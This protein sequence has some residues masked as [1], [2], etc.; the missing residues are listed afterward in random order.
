[1]ASHSK[2]ITLVHHSAAGWGSLS[3]REVID[4]LERAGHAVRL[5]D[6]KG[7]YDAGLATSADVVIAAG[8]D[9]TLL[10]V[11]RRLSG[12]STPMMV[13]PVGTAN[14]LARTI[15]TTADLA[16][17]LE[18]L[19]APLER[20]LDLGIATGSWGERYFAESVGVGW[21]CDALGGGIDKRDKPID[22]ALVRLAELLGRYE[23]RAWSLTVDGEDA[24]GAYA[25][26]DVMNA[27]MVGPNLCFAPEADPF[28]GWLDVVLAH[29]AD[30]MRA[31]RYIEALRADPSTP[32]P[33]LDV[34]R[35][36]HV[37][38]ALESAER[39]RV[40]GTLCPK[41]DAPGSHFADVRVL[42]AAVRLWSPR[43]ER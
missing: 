38:F 1:M 7:G 5:V 43:A 25:F 4:R 14:N 13:L 33:G 21:F 2:R 32:S 11:A 6:A 3:S 34:R 27:R 42:P 15:G 31:H 18:T 26:V 29:A 8:G 39:I 22:R 9:G 23:P 30:R 36:K 12:S 10:G 37:R 20:A 17:L 19:D 41:K 16:A 40:D 35:A 24:S 28:D